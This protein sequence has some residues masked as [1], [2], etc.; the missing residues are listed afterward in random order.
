MTAKS[1]GIDMARYPDEMHVKTSS[2]N[3]LTMANK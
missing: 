1:I 2:A 3:V